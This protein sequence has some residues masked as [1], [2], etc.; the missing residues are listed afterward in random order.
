MK[1]SHWNSKTLLLA[2]VLVIGCG[3]G[4]TLAWLSATTGE[5]VNTFTPAQVT[6]EIEEE[7]DQGVKE[8]VTVQN[9]GDVEA[10]I[11]AKIV[12]NWAD[13]QGNISAVVPVAGTDYTMTLSETTWV[14]IGEYYYYKNSVAPGALTDALIDS[15]TPIGEAPEGYALQVIILAEG[16]Q[17]SPTTAMQKSWGVDPELWMKQ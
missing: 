17:S 8:N 16:I 12:V 6:T 13:A 14:Q 11:R 7:L 9:T 2:V 15:C 1:K 10:Y 3:L 5:V 4:G